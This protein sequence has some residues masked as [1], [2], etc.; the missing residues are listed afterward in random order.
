M[1][2]TKKVGLIG[3]LQGYIRETQ[4]EAKKVA[5]PSREHVV[6]ASV[7]IVILVLVIAFLTGF[8]DFIIGEVISSLIKVRR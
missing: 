4:V 3:G 1:E 8:L 2:E 5:W 7:L 6:S